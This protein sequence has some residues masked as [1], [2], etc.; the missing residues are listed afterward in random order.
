MKISN[1]NRQLQLS[2]RSCVIRNACIK[3]NIY[4]CWRLFDILEH[5]TVVNVKTNGRGHKTQ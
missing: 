3:Q 2:K 1:Q 4:D 5:F